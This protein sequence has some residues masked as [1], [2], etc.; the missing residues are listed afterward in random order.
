MYFP[1]SQILFYL[2]KKRSNSCFVRL[3]LDWR[4]QPEV[5]TVVPLFPLCR[6]H[7]TF[8]LRTLTPLFTFTGK[9]LRSPSRHCGPQPQSGPP[10]QLHPPSPHTDSSTLPAPHSTTPR[11][12]QTPP[13]LLLLPLRVRPRQRPRHPSRKS[14]PSDGEISTSGSALRVPAS[15]PLPSLDPTTSARLYVL[16]KL[17]NTIII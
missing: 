7:W 11:N 2:L 17:R 8:P 16:S 15:L 4:Q 3:S 12:Q 14:S 13:L 9:W 6:L 5:L 1:D 10:S